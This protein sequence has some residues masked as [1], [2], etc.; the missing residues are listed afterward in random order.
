M[1]LLMNIVKPAN[2]KISHSER[3]TYQGGINATIIK[4]NKTIRISN[5]DKKLYKY[6]KTSF[7]TDDSSIFLVTD[8][9]FNKLKSEGFNVIED[10]D[11]YNTQKIA[12]TYL[13]D[14]DGVKISAALLKNYKEIIY[15]IHETHTLELIKLLYPKALILRDIIPDSILK[16]KTES[17]KMLSLYDVKRILRDSASRFKF[18]LELPAYL[19]MDKLSMFD[20]KDIKVSN[21]KEVIPDS[22]IE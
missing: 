10:I 5:S 2:I 22:K 20:S 16:T 4:S 13:E 1:S 18:Q 7:A 9:N 21:I 3:A 15:D 17:Q 19:F 11:A 12:E 6:V 8:K 14:V